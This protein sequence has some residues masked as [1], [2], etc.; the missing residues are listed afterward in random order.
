MGPFSAGWTETDVEGVI[1]RGDPSELLYVPIVVGM[2]AADC[3]QAWAEG[4]CF[5]LAGHEDFNVRGNAIL[6]LGH[7]ART[8]GAL[9]LQLAVPLIARGLF[10]PHD[11]VRGQA[12]SAAGDLQV[13]LGVAVPGYDMSQTEELV[14]AIEACR[15]AHDT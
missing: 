3:D 6:G 4:I 13:Y 15:R 11:Y 7:I 12:D 8:R 9:N 2:N 14:N 1:A 5:S 10:D